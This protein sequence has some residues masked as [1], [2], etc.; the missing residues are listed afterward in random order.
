MNVRIDRVTERR[1]VGRPAISGRARVAALLAFGSLLARIAAADSE[2]DINFL[3]E[4]ALESAMDAHYIA[5]PWP[6]G[7]LDRRQPRFSVDLSAAHTE[8]DFIEVDG[9]MVAVA[10]ASGLTDQ[11]GYEAMGFY[12][13][14]RVSGGVGLAPLEADFLA[15]P[16]DLPA[17]AEFA[18]PRGTLRQFGVGG[19]AV[20]QQG[21]GDTRSA[22]FIAGFVLEQVDARGYETDYV[23]AG[24][25]DAGAAGIVDHSGT[26]TFVTPFVSWQRT[27]ALGTRWSWSPRATVAW[28][29][30]ANDFDLR[31]TG[32]GFDVSSAQTG[33]PLRIGDPFAVLGLALTHRPS[34]FEIDLGETALFPVFEQVS[35]PGVDQAWVVH[36]AWR[37]R[38]PVR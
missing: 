38:A 29:L 14:M 30:P 18:N 5:L 25:A 28:P 33:T 4:H 32:P 35:H 22:Q 2:H 37:Q 11:W 1:R 12:S 34:G 20:R 19:A 27:R 13:D 10:A 7:Q 26:A 15:V 36:L 9:P 16:L 24:G 17:P 31:L 8:T 3:K 21:D 23:L 6:P